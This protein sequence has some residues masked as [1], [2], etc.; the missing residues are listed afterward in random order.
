ML[1]EGDI[2]NWRSCNWWILWRYLNT[3]FIIYSRWVDPSWDIC[4]LK[5]LCS[6]YNFS[7]TW[8]F[9]HN[10][11]TWMQHIMYWNTITW[12]YKIIWTQREYLNTTWVFEYSMYLNTTWVFKHNVSINECNMSIWMQLTH[13]WIQREYI[14]EHNVSIRM[15][16]EYLNTTW[17]LERN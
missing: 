9:E 2:F 8:I 3:L 1:T 4:T 5:N 11:S 14:A 7:A 13:F 6:P 15:Q 16:R 12:V 10:V 17:V